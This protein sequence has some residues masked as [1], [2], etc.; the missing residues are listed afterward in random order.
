MPP[1]ACRT[2]CPKPAQVQQKP[3]SVGQ[4]TGSPKPADRHATEGLAY[5]GEVQTGLSETLV[6][7]RT[8]VGHMV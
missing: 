7:R 6:V 3:I 8:T 4:R 5:F 1:L 2:I